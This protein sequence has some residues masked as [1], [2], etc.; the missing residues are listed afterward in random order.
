MRSSVPPSGKPDR[1][2]LTHLSGAVGRRDAGHLR[3]P[4]ALVD[5]GPEELL[6]RRADLRRDRRAADMRDP[7][8]RQPLSKACNLGQRDTHRRHPEQDGH[9]DLGHQVERLASVEAP[10]DRDRAARGERRDDA[11][12]QPEHVRERSRAEDDVARAELERGRDV[13]RCSADAAVRQRRT[14]RLPR[15]PRREQD[16]RRGVRV[17]GEHVSHRLTRLELLTVTDQQL[18]RGDEHASIHLGLGQQG[19]ERYDDR[20]EPPDAVEQ[21]HEL[22]PVRQHHAHPI[23]DRDTARPEHPRAPGRALGES[24]VRHGGSVGHER[25]SVCP[26]L[27]LLE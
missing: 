13:R 7:E 4:V 17:A 22:R 27:G 5:V 1:A 23:A 24:C 3:H 19:I 6:E 25:R 21:R 11:R 14:L 18:R 16:H 26:L 12:R 10:L 9:A 15:R 2:E 20:A 8:G